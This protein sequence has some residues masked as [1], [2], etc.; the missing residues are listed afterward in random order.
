MA[1]KL[2]WDGRQDALCDNSIKYLMQ[3]LSFTR[4][5]VQI[6]YCTLFLLL[7]ILKID[8]MRMTYMY[9]HTFHPV[10]LKMHAKERTYKIA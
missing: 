8:G 3:F 9:K 2:C 7:G 6:T 10:R 5:S 1:P 4:K